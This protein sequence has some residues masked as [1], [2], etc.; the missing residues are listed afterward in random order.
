MIE[1]RDEPLSRQ[2]ILRVFEL[3]ERRAF[4]FLLV[5]DEPAPHGVTRIVEGSRPPAVRNV[6]GERDRLKRRRIADFQPAATTLDSPLAKDRGGDVDAAH[7]KAHVRLP[8][9]LVRRVGAAFDEDVD[10]RLERDD[11]AQRNAEC[12]DDIERLVA[13]A[14]GIEDDAITNG[15]S[16]A[17]RRAARRHAL[18]DRPLRE[19]R[20]RICR[21]PAS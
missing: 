16:P 13:C 20:V 10:L 14:A 17:S 9:A 2:P 8:G 15:E 12:P 7:A 6:S 5:E 3:G 18:R 19:L 1:G 11:V 4:G 21:R